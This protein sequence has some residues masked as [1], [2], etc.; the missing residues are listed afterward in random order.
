[1]EHLAGSSLPQTHELW[2]RRPLHSDEINH[3][4]LWL[5]VSAS[6]GIAGA[7]WLRLNLPVPVCTFHMLTGIP[8]PGCGSTRAMRQLLEGNFEQALHFNPLTVCVFAAI[9]IFDLYAVL[10]LLFRLPRIRVG[11]L[12]PKFGKWTRMFVLSSIALN[13]AW[14]IHAGL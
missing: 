9:A 5:G 7:L 13:W 2:C 8:C 10:V 3:E 11:P 6:A 14:V 1:M 4:A 12:P